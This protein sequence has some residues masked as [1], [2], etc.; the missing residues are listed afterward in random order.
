MNKPKITQAADLFNLTLLGVKVT[1]L[2]NFV[3][4]PERKDYQFK[5]NLEMHKILNLVF[6]K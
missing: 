1:F 5:M 3:A 4:N 2:F 6:P